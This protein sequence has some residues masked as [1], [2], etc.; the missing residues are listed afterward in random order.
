V[1]VVEDL[2]VFEGADRQFDPGSPLLPVE[3]LR[4]ETALPPE[5]DSIG[6]RKGRMELL[7]RVV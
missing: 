6:E 3:Q 5:F 7:S 4:L 1:A 2:E